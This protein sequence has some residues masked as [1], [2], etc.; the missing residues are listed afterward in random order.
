MISVDGP[1]RSVQV[2]IFC[3]R[4]L[5]RENNP[6]TVGK[7]L[8]VVGPALGHAARAVNLARGL[9]RRGYEIHFAGADTRKL[10][11]EVVGSEFPL[12][13]LAGMDYAADVSFSNALTHC[14][15][16]LLPSAICY[17]LSPLPWLAQ[18]A[19]FPV[20]EVYI[21]NA[22]L[23]RLGQDRTFQDAMFAK[24]ATRWN[25][26]RAQR[27]IP[28]LTDGR[29]LYERDLVLL[30]D[31]PDLLAGR[32][33]PAHYRVIGPCSWNPPTALPDE[34]HPMQH[35][36]YIS[37]G[38]TGRRTLPEALVHR[39]AE[40]LACPHIV[41]VEGEETLKRLT[42][43]SYARLPGS[44]VLERAGFALTQGGTGSVYQALEKGVPVG[45]WPHDHNHQ[46][47]GRWV[48]Q[49]GLA[50]L[51]EPESW[52]TKIDGLREQLPQLTARARALARSLDALD[53]NFEASEHI[54][55]LLRNR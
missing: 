53:G 42:D 2:T 44:A 28:P 37:M 3:L 17:D 23:T 55:T 13:R 32:A 5:I 35:I 25:R 31:P 45:C 12:H 48:E 33:L 21:T 43:Y 46:V 14:M 6:G 19:R 40:E 49:K 16:R 26:L 18:L 7:I 9:R 24:H 8:F 30:A 15:E 10:T 51:F 39:L 29:A 52:E 20:P 36:L 1:V 11:Q 54:D 47:F 4:N 22:F 41:A 27:G 34:I 50:V 38:S